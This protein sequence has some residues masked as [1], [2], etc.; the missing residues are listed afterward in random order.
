MPLIGLFVKA[1]LD[2]VKRIIFPDGLDWTVDVTMSNGPDVRERVTVNSIE[3]FEVPNS[4]GTA[5]FVMKWEGAKQASTM[6]LVTQTRKTPLKDLK[7]GQNLGEYT[8]EDNGA[9]KP[10]VVFDCRGV[11][12]SNWYPVGPFQ[13]E[14][15]GGATFSEVDLS[16]KDGWVEYDEENDSSV[17]IQDL[18]F[19]FRTMR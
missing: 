14:S 12:P 16:D 6:S 4:K 15:A 17:T 10:V 13:V 11:E 7:K 3:E 18:A 8:S 9:F 1:E 5:N 2:N 19:E